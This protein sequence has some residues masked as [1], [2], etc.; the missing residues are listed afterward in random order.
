MRQFCELLPKVKGDFDAFEGEVEEFETIGS[1][2]AVL[3][4]VASTSAQ[5]E[6]LECDI[7]SIIDIDQVH[8][9]HPSCE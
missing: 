4:Q 6:G 8:H 5:L 3:D 2:S 9:I 1:N 7:R